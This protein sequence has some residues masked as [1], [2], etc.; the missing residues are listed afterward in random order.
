MLRAAALASAPLSFGR[1]DGQSPTHIHL[2][3]QTIAF[4]DP[5]AVADSVFHSI[6]HTH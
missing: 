4:S 1:L 3:I 6:S 5:D 2:T